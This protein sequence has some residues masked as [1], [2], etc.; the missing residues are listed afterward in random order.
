MIQPMILPPQ[1]YF[2]LH[3]KKRFKVTYGGR[4]S[5][6]S[7]SYAKALIA[8]AGQLKVRVLCA[9]EIQSSIKESVYQLLKE[10][11]YAHHLEDRHEFT[12]S[13][14]RNTETGSEFF[15]YGLRTDPDKIKSMQ[16]I[17]ICFIEEADKISDQAWIDLIPTVRTPG[18]EI[19]IVF[20]TGSEDDPVYRRFIVNQPPDCI[21]CKLNYT[22]VPQEWLSE[23][24]KKEAEYCK[25]TDL[26]AY[27]HI[28][29]G[30]PGGQGGRIW[31]PFDENVH[32][33]EFEWPFVRTRAQAFMA[34]DPHSKFFPFCVWLARWLVADDVY[35]YW[36]YNEWPEY[37]LYKKFY[38][39]FRKDKL[40]SEWGGLQELAQAIFARDGS[41]FGMKVLRRFI[42]TR[43]AK[44]A[45]GENWSTG[46]QGV[47]S[48]LSNVGIEMIAPPERIIDIQ[49]ECILAAMKYNRGAPINEFNRP[50]FYV[51][52]WC[53]NTIQSLKFHRT[54]EQSER[55][56]ER[57][58]DPSDAM[59]ICF[60]G[61][62]LPVIDNSR[63][64]ETDNEYAASYHGEG[65][66]M[67]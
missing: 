63:K 26:A 58:K 65:G 7:T 2:L 12:Q 52:P 6:K 66:W 32:V 21:V 51:A 44:G 14:I 18:S 57:Q 13:S 48:E 22:D 8:R 30:E 9:R 27:R 61:M 3:A 62:T 47:V 43:F 36:I 5:T 33:R 55:E 29:L 37:A 24:T 49:R 16:T 46:T 39:E 10:Q 64:K 38:S 42:D 50:N 31:T 41:E 56:S 19:W 4:S 67:T 15:F 45:G 23:E 28:W 34:M 54:E 59:R 17:D 40:L 53:R 35:T 25:R 1:L 11:I 20:N 60:A